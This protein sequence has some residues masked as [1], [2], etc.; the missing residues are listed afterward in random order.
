MIPYTIVRYYLSDKGIQQK[1]SELLL[2]PKELQEA[3][4]V[5]YYENGSW[6]K[7]KGYR[8]R[9]T[10]ALTGTP[11][12]TGLYEFVKR[13]GTKKF[14][15]SA[16]ALYYNQQDDVSA[17]AIGGGLTFT[18]GSEGQNF[19][20]F[21]TFANQVIGTNGVEAI[22]K[23][24]GSGNAS[25][26]GGSPP[27][28]EKIVVFQNFVFLA[29]NDTYPYRL[30]FSNDGNEIIWT[31]TDYIDI[32][33]LTSPITGLAVLYN[34]LYI[35]TR[36][37]I[38]SLRGYDR[39]TFIVDDVNS[40]VGCVAYKS[41]VKVDNNLIFLSDRG[42]YSFDGIQVH[43]ISEKV[44]VFIENLNYTRTDKVVAEIYKA[45]NQVWFSV[46]TGSNSN[47]NEVLV[48]TYDTTGSENS[49]I[50][51][52]EVA[53]AEYTGMAFN[54]FG[55]E[56]STTELDRLYAGDYAGLMF[57]QDYGNND[58]GLGIAFKVKTPPIDMGAP[59][60][61]K[62]FRYMWIF[63]KQEGNYNLSVSYVTDF[64]FGGSTTTI[65]LS[66][67]GN[68]SLWGTMVWGVDPWGGGKIVKS[69]VGF[70]AKGHFM[71][72]TFENS[73]SEQPIVIKGFS[74]C[75]QLKNIGRR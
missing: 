60:Q 10:N 55:L 16:N 35:F 3:K 67:V 45:K 48:M 46:S 68:T 40:S 66:V 38:F 56:T 50:T 12:I 64:G 28:A 59:E 14:L 43:Y 57:Q 4:N 49:I 17:T 36:R 29:G 18:V 30:Y 63:N 6:T 71:E 72:I 51:K 53:F 54:V 58:N 37:G 23:W 9:L 19:M 47:N 22:W 41:I 13:D 73:G 24:S 75:A 11:I 20:S 31:A 26:L 7:R 27:I 74:I 15:T 52:N 32:G 44:Q 62:R 34:T 5:H 2:T 8:K 65:S 33:D 21:V 70:K 69:R 61:F 25:A 1:T 39:D 42:I